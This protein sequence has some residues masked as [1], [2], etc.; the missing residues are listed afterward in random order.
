MRVDQSNRI[1]KLREEL[2]RGCRTDSLPQSK[3][4]DG[5]RSPHVD[6]IARA[7]WNRTHKRLW[8]SRPTAETVMR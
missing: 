2:E 6:K 7:I 5:L 1:S 3:T 4:M 8:N